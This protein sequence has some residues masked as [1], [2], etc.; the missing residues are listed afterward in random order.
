MNRATLHGIATSTS[1]KV[2]NLISACNYLVTLILKFR[3]IVKNYHY[4][5]QKNLCLID[6]DCGSP[7]RICRRRK[8]GG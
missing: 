5:A 1:A 8:A 7:C 6:D 3:F 4:Y 2:V